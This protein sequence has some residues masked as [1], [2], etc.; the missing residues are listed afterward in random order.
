MTA[1][2]QRIFV[3][4]QSLEGGGAQRRV[5]DLANGFVREGRDVDVFLVE[6]SGKLRDRLSSQV[7]LFGVDELA[8]RLHADPP[9]ALLSG[10][11]AVHGVA[12][13]SLPPDRRFP[14]VL[15][16]SSHPHRNFPWSMLRQRIGEIVRRR[17]RMAAYAAADLIIA[18]ADAVA[19]P[20]RREFP[21]KPILV[22][23]NHVVTDEFLAGAT[24]RI[25]FPWPDE[26]R[27]PLIVAIGRHAVAKDFPTLVRAFAIV[28]GRRPARLAIIGGGPTARRRQLVDLARK[29]GV[30]TNV[31]LVDHS[32]EIAAWLS[33]AKL[34]VSSSLWEGAPAVLVEALA[35]GCPVVATDSPGAA[36]EILADRELGS[37]VPPRR[38]REMAEAIAEWLDRPVN[39]ERL[40][41]ATKPYRSDPAKAYLSA[42]NSCAERLLG[43]SA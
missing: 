23:R 7:R 2:A 31:A 37:L 11:A 32:A 43:S 6:P 35:M 33:R 14:L 1:K 16:A 3:L 15:R 42:I 27:V 18:V 38:P 17:K 19:E 13:R 25:D 28:R 41:A 34:L 39:Q 40:W 30:E 22:I 12:V 24:A 21:D 36:R 8:A 9:G 26:P 10:A 5:I 4:L 20:L 29:L